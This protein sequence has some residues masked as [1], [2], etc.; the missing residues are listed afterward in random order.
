MT[1][2]ITIEL[3]VRVNPETILLDMP[4]VEDI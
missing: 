4:I 3:D 2:V 1:T